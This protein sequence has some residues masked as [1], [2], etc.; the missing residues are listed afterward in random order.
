MKKTFKIL[1]IIL[2][3][4]V[5]VALLFLVYATVTDYEPY[6]IETI[7]QSENP[8]VLPDSMQI[9]LMIW[10]IGYAGL[11]AE[12]DFFYDGGSQVRTSRR[13]TE[14]NLNAITAF[15]QKNDSLDFILL[16]E[17]DKK[18]KRS[19]R[20]NQ[21]KS[22]QATLVDYVYSFGTNYDVFFVPV[23]L[24][25]PLGKVFSGI[26]S[27]SKHQPAL[28][29]RRAF[30]GN[31][32]WPKKLFL[33]DRC[34]MVSRFFLTSGKELLIINTHNSAYD[35][36]TLRK[37]QMDYLKSFL[38]EE[39]QKGNYIIVGGDWNQCPPGFLP[40]FENNIFD[41]ENYDVIPKDYMHDSWNWVYDS[42]TPTN[43]RVKIPYHPQ[44]CPTTVIDFYLTSP[45]VE[46]ISV[47]T[48]NLNFEHSDHQP[49]IAQFRL[50]PAS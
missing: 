20:I 36:G 47:N 9:S 44:K 40:E 35:D 49:V 50:K 30:P 18:S 19:Y 43:R 37:Q 27:L 1:L 23:P 46:A 11:S 4:L 24:S 29:L 48:I 17:V 31:Y 14:T 28:T 34:F 42:K 41:K 26:S 15:L 21:Y 3:S 5:G 45:N 39:Y 33:L 22:I 25:S 12:M 38:L 10:N 6:E 16:Q 32:S 7:Q 13:Q 8:D 2:L